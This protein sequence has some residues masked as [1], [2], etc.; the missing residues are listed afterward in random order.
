MFELRAAVMNERERRG[1]G[2]GGGSASRVPFSPQFEL[3]SPTDGESF[4]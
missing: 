1:R 2:E 3:F 4:A